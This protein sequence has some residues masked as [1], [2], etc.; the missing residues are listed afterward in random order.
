[1]ASPIPVPAPVTIAILSFKRIGEP[2]PARSAMAL[3]AASRPVTLKRLI[4]S[5]TDS[6]TQLK[7]AVRLAGLMAHKD[8][9]NRHDDSRNAF[10]HQL[11]VRKFLV[12]QH[13]EKN[14]QDYA[15]REHEQRCRAANRLDETQRCE[16]QRV[17]SAQATPEIDHFV[18]GIDRKDR[19]GAR[20]K[21]FDK[22]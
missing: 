5:E 22:C 9:A 10:A 20:P 19:A 1:M 16:Q 15:E 8:G 4:A 17:A 12:S 14:G 7:I 3:R 13:W 21:E 18:D 6:L 11:P 2:F